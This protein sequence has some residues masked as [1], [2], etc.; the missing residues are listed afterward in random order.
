MRSCTETASAVSKAEAVAAALAPELTRRSITTR[1]VSVELKPVDWAVELGDTAVPAGGAQ[2]MIPGIVKKVV[3]VV[4][5][6]WLSCSPDDEIVHSSQVGWFAPPA[7]VTNKVAVDV[8]VQDATVAGA[9]G[10]A[11]VVVAGVPAHT[12]TPVA[13]RRLPSSASISDEATRTSMRLAPASRIRGDAVTSL[14]DLS[15]RGIAS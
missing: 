14:T 6:T 3:T 15:R 8:L 12:Q 9:V 5:L 11:Q 4:P 13:K 2:F 7:L 1:P 10:V